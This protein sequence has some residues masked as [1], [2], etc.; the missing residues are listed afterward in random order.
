MGKFMRHLE[1]QRLHC[2]S[3]TKSG[4]P[5]EQKVPRQMVSS[6][7]NWLTKETFTRIICLTTMVFR[8]ISNMQFI[9][10]VF[11]PLWDVGREN[12]PAV[13]AEC[14]LTGIGLTKKERVIAGR[15][16]RMQLQMKEIQMIGD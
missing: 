7:K 11:S 15:N 1:Y 8:R 4:V 3:E 5:V 14:S 12:Y 13:V 10:S 16:R 2:K 6:P 9:G